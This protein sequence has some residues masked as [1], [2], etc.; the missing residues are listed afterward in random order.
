[1]KTTRPACWSVNV[2]VVVLRCFGPVVPIQGREE[3]KCSARAPDEEDDGEDDGEDGEEETLGAPGSDAVACETT[4]AA[5]VAL[6]VGTGAVTAGG[7]TAVGVTAGG[8]T[9]GTVTGR[10]GGAGTVTVG[11]VGTGGIGTGPAPATARTAA[12]TL[13][14]Q[15]LATAPNGCAHRPIRQNHGKWPS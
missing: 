8:G 4:G 14:P 7:V 1:M 13:I 12:R 3:W 5:G 9:F 15:Q 10:G 6:A 11:T 2:S